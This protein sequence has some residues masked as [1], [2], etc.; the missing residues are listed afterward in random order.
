MTGET[1]EILCKNIRDMTNTHD[2]GNIWSYL[3]LSFRP[4]VG[5]SKSDTFTKLHLKYHHN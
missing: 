1:E 2:L 3:R 5:L 4:R